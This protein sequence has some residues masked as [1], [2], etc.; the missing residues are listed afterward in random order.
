MKIEKIKVAIIGYGNIG[1]Y[2]IEAIEATLDMELIGIVRRSN[3]NIPKE[4]HNYK[5]VENID[6]LGKLDVAL[7]CCPTRNVEEIASKILAKG[8]NTVDS[9]DIHG[10]ILNL[11]KK[12]NEIAKNNNVVSLISAGWDPGS[13][14][15]I[16]T[17]LKAIA[18]CGLTY[19]NFGPGMSMGHTVVAKSKT[20]VEDALSM[21]MPLGDG[22]HRRLVYLQMKEN[23]DF[24]LACKEIKADSYFLNDET[25]FFKVGN[26][27]ELIDM[28][29]ATNIV[30][31]G[32]SGKTQNQLFNFSMKINNP[33]LT[34]QIMVACAR[35]TMKLEKG[36]YTMIEI[37]LIKLLAGDEENL[38]RELV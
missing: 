32:A 22:I 36:C 7:L 26:L 19:T 16:R 24:D 37:P 12:L 29:H 3:K 2:A 14:S 30:R 15:I 9:F 25:K 33:A 31:K 28:G 10:E 6:D 35:A 21:T 34:S 17:L 27:K 11:K 23:A 38:I 13:D 20:G 4:L 1:K 5:I 18:P 8:I